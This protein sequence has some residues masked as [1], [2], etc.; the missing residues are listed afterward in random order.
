VLGEAVRRRA[1]VVSVL[2]TD[3]PAGFPAEAVGQLLGEVS[4]SLPDG[5]VALYV[6][7][8]C[9]DLGCGAVTALVERANDDV[10]WRDLGWRPIT[11]QRSTRNPSG[12]WARSGSTPPSTRRCCG[13][14]WIPPAHELGDHGCRSSGVA[15]PGCA[16]SLAMRGVVCGGNSVTRRRRG[17]GLEDEL[18]HRALVAEAHR[19]G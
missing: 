19:A 3:W 13:R 11:T 4:S 14:C 1:D 9:G 7:P 6:C 12:S 17:V 15:A 2:V 5:R 18:A 8:E 10:V 16:A